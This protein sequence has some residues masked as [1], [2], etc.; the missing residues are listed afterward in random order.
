MPYSHIIF[1]WDGTV[2]DSADK[3][4]SCMQLAARE[5]ELAVPSEDDVRHII[6]ISLTPAIEQLFSI[7]LESAEKVAAHYKRIFLEVDSTPSPLFFG[8]L[9]TL[10]QLHTSHVLGVATGKARR[11]LERAWEH[12]DTKQYFSASRCADEAESKPSPD[13]LLQLI[14]HWQVKPESVLMIGDTVYDLQM[15]QAIG[16]PRLGVSFGVHSSD[17]LLQHEPIAI[18]DEFNDILNYIYVD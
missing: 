11:G 3:I 5:A 2:M 10:Q 12:T 8:A 17:A 9:N 7:S 4:V 14:K 18:V 15:A 13:M 1:D 16:M 6:G